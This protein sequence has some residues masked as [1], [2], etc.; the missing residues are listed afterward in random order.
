MEG[1]LSEFLIN[2]ALILVPVLWVVGKIV[3]T[4]AIIADKWIPLSLLGAGVVLAMMYLG[5]SVE[6]GLQGA[7]A[8]GV[9]VFGHQLLKQSK[10]PE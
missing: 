4:S 3:K 6:S 9:A 1:L 5:V 7:I 10:E 2:R 8:A